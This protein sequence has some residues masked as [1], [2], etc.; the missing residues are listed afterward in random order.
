MNC[1]NLLDITLETVHI[2]ITRT[3]QQLCPVQLTPFQEK[4]TVLTQQ[5]SVIH[6]T[7]EGVIVHESK[8]RV[9]NLNWERH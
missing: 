9:N 1:F 4:F 8:K 2:T 3:E 5:R 6:G 7:G